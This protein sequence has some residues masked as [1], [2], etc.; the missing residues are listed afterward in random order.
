M[1]LI[2]ATICLILAGCGSVPGRF[3]N[4]I[5]VSLT[6]DRA[7][8]SSLYGPIGVTAE[9]R[10]EDAAE[11]KRIRAAAASGVAP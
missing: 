7:F 4:L 1:K 3:D 11:L 8:V 10:K 9:L 5:T 2:L 6:G